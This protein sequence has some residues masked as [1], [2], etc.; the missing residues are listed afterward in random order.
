MDY[1]STLEHIEQTAEIALHTISTLYSGHENLLPKFLLLSGGDDYYD[2]SYNQPLEDKNL[3]VRVYYH[4]D[5][6]SIQ[7]GKNQLEYTDFSTMLNRSNGYVR[8][9][10]PYS[11]LVVYTNKSLQEIYDETTQLDEYITKLRQLAVDD[12]QGLRRTCAEPRK[13]LDFIIE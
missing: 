8:F 12:L 7:Y 4:S 13:D 10:P 11:K 2:K 9:T 5:Y 1:R 6:F 3:F